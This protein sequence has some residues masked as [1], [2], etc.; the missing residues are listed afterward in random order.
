MEFLEVFVVLFEGDHEVFGPPAHV[1]FSCCVAGNL[2]WGKEG[3]V[4]TFH[5]PFDNG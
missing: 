1:M 3:F 5:A 2:F 4:G